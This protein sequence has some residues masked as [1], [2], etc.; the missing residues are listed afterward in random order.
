[1]KTNIFYFSSTG[2]GLAIA[3]DL[4]A[5]LP[6]VYIY[7]IPEVIAGPD[8]EAENIG[9]VFPVYYAGMPRIVTQFLEKLQPG[10]NKYIF[11]VCS[12]GGLPMGTLFQVQR[13][14]QGNGLELQAGFNINMPG[15][16]IVKYGAFSAEKQAK[17]FA[18]KNKKIKEIARTVAQRKKSRIEGNGPIINFVGDVLS[19]QMLPKF[20]TLDRNFTVS[21][22]CIS[23]QNCAKVCPVQDI[24]MEGGRPRWLGNCEHCLACIQW[25][26][27][28]AIQ[29]GTQTIDRKRYH[30]P[31]L[32]EKDFYREEAKP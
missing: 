20:P 17:L 15:N 1:M 6:D 28:E 12:C 3:R 29:Y 13:Q 32:T 16:Y 22:K 5:H 19:R 27:T 25:C 7:S 8:L 31:G 26:P 30:Y 24:R 10:Q 2:N 11:A 23:C 14:L 18:A 4:A 9:I 21:E